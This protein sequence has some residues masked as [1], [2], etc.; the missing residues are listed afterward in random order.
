[1]QNVWGPLCTRV[2]FVYCAFTHASSEVFPYT[3]AHLAN[4][5][6]YLSKHMNVLKLMQKYDEVEA[7]HLSEEELMY[8]SREETEKQNEAFRELIE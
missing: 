6:D 1:M 3:A 4:A 7:P 5:I 8:W 2:K